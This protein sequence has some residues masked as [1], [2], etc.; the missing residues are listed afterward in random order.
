MQLG[1][2]QLSHSFQYAASASDD[3]ELPPKSDFEPARCEEGSRCLGGLKRMSSLIKQLVLAQSCVTFK[4]VAASLTTELDPDSSKGAK[5]IRRRVYDAINVL[6]AVGVLEKR[7]SLVRWKAPVPATTDL[8]SRVELTKQR[9]AEKRARLFD[10]VRKW[11][12]LKH[13]LARNARSSQ[14]STLRFPFMLVSTQDSPQNGI[15]LRYEVGGRRLSARF[16]KPFQV[17]GDLDVLLA[18]NLHL[19]DTQSFNKFVSQPGLRQVLGIE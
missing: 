19:V 16:T 5:N 2:S 14:R 4:E 6:L 8:S 9:V 11:V 12:A 15:G 17:F 10:V 18:L 7:Q 1:Y 13:L 3:D